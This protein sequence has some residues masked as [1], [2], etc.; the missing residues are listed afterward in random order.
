MGPWKSLS[1]GI[2]SNK[3]KKCSKLKDR[4]TFPI[5]KTQ[6]LQSQTKHT[7][8]LLVIKHSRHSLGIEESRTLPQPG[9]KALC[10]Q[11]WVKSSS[12][13][14]HCR[15]AGQAVAHE[16]YIFYGCQFHPLSIQ[17]HANGLRK[18]ANNLSTW[19]SATHV[20]K[21]NKFPGS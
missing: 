5:P 7:H 21:Q 6:L 9:I 16:A 15:V 18:A 14:I 11:P 19:A 17:L 1:E 8:L 20:G 12:R 10:D 3:E 13:G 2:M 4:V